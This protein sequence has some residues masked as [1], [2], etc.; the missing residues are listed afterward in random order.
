MWGI[1]VNKSV[2]QKVFKA[3]YEISFFIINV[4]FKLIFQPLEIYW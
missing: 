3:F 1:V 2:F 4:K